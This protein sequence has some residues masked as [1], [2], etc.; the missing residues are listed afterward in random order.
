MKG[1]NFFMAINFM[2]LLGSM[3]Q[4]SMSSPVQ[5]SR[6]SNAGS[7]IQDI[8]SS[9]MGAGQTVKNRVGGDNLAA[10]GIGALLGALMGGSSSTTANTLGGGMMGL[11]GMMAYKALKNSMGG[12]S[13]SS[14]L[15]S[16]SQS[17]TMQSYVQPTQQQQNSD[18]E[19][20]LLAM[21]DAAKADG[22]VDSGE[23][24]K[25]MNTMKSSG[26]GQEGMNY[27]I[28][29]LQGPM[30]TAKIIS[31]VRGRPELAAQV[32]SASLMSIEVDTEAERKYLDKLAK[33]MGL[34]P[35]V[36]RNIEQLTSS[37]SDLQC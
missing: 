27:V 13:A 17:Q 3:V 16:Q 23:L 22:Q 37:D 15:Q 2:D 18:A 25:I 19:I 30:E 35:E 9:L 34:T 24:G 21:I 1:A 20:I 5:S 8:L 10:G 12:A 36:V 7:G 32:Y 28:Q 33:A 11:L 6:M 4:G 31:A 26:I 29:K 14:S